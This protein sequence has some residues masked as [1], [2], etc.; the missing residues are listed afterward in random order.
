MVVPGLYGLHLALL[1]VLAHLRG[2]RASR[3][4]TE[5]IARYQS[6]TPD[7]HWPIVTTQLPLYNE[8]AVARRVIEATARM[9][10]PK[11]RHEIQV[12]DDSTDGTCA[13]VDEVCAELRAAG[14]DVKAVR[15]P[16]RADFKAGALAH[17][18]QTARGELIAVFDADFVPDPG[19][20]KRMVPLLA[21]DPMACCVQGRWGHLN[22]RES[23][24]TQSLALA[25]D[26]HFALE[27]T[28]RSSFGFCLNFNGTGGIWR[29]AAIEDPAVGGWSG[30]T[31]TEDLDLSY[32]AQMAGWHILYHNDELCPAEIP[33]SIDAMKT[34]QRRWATGSIQCAVKLLPVVWRS[35]L[36]L[37]QKIEATLHMTQYSIAIFMVL[38]AAGGRVILTQIPTDVQ[39][40]WMGAFWAILPIVIAAPSA[41]YV[42]ARWRVGGGLS[43]LLQIP[44]LIVLGLG[45]SVNNA[46]AVLVGLWQKGG[47]FIRTPKSGSA[48]RVR[49][50]H[51]YNAIRSR[52]WLIEISLG[53]ACLAQW[54]LFLVADHYVGGIFLLAYAIGL[55]S[56]GWGSRPTA[57]PAKPRIAAESPVPLDQPST[58]VAA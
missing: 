20:L 15:R 36:S 28:A 29:K 10:Y 48:G 40:A 49:R 25:M 41:S 56:L 2:R 12:L 44:K 17:G 52:L 32:R 11:G 26:G 16:S 19:F 39:Q 45:L 7:E 31:I 51:A 57:M 5:V 47:E 24:V 6:Q 8:L 18:M 22:Q 34:Q 46:H 30:D 35:R 37:L 9:E 4:N 1:A 43:G 27:Q 33:A 3:T 13:I 50:K 42:Y 58:S 14:Y 53:V 55:I 38:M 21:S 54:G 23:W